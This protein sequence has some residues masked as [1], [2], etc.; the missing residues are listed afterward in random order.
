M[1]V[2]KG[3]KSEA[4]LYLPAHYSQEI[5]KF[6]DDDERPTRNLWNIE[7]ILN[8]VFPKNYQQR[9]YESALALMRRLA[10]SP[11]ISSSEIPK[12]IKENNISKATL[13]NRV[14]PKMKRFGLIKV[15]REAALE[16]KPRKFKISLSKSF[17]NYL[18]KISDSWLA[19]VDDA[20]SSR[21]PPPSPSPPE[22]ASA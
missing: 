16:G 20:R 14:I 2:K 4:S 1:E 13:Y 9:Y 17:G 5:R 8:F 18:M 19:F 6:E 11:Y 15:E 7:E 22:S 21:E 12:L 10:S 3:F